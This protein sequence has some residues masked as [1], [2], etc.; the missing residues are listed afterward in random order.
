MSFVQDVM[1]QT[2][3]AMRA[4]MRSYTFQRTKSDS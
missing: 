1:G 3:T 4:K 2:V